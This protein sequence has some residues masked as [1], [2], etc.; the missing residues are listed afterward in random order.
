MTDRDETLKNLYTIRAGLSLL[1]QLKDELDGLKPVPEKIKKRIPVERALAE[2][3][4]DNPDSIYGLGS[5]YSFMPPVKVISRE[6][7]VSYAERLKALR[8]ACD[9]MEEIRLT[10]WRNANNK[11]G[12]PPVEYSDGYFKKAGT[13]KFFDSII[14][15]MY[16][17]KY[18]GKNPRRLAKEEERKNKFRNEIIAGLLKGDYNTFYD[19]R[20]HIELKI[21]IIQHEENYPVFCHY[22]FSWLYERYKLKDDGYQEYIDKLVENHG[23]LEKALASVERTI[24]KKTATAIAVSNILYETYTDFL[25]LSQW[26]NIDALIYYVTEGYADTIKEALNL[27]LQQQQNDR[28]VNAIAGMEKKI[29]D[30]VNRGISSLKSQMNAGFENLSAQLDDVYRQQ[31]VTNAQLTRANHAIDL[32]NVLRMKANLTSERLADDMSYFRSLAQ[33]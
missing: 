22:T 31:T 10:A 5:S 32:N 2:V 11:D 3:C 18:K 26:K 25:P 21:S 6:I 14:D 27:M 8:D 29:T 13:C 1:S 33:G 28:L 16:K 9:S 4:Y 30:A 17:P 15:E 7:A 20:K 24:A 12:A 19:I 23:S